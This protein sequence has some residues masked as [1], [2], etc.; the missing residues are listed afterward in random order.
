MGAR[1]LSP[2][3]ESVPP[4]RVV[5]IIA[6]GGQGNRLGADAPKQFLEIGGRTMLD[7][8]IA[9]FDAHPRVAALVVALPAA[10]M[11]DPPACLGACAK[12]LQLVAGGERRQDSVARA[13]EAIEPP[14]DVVVVHDAARP[15]VDAATIDRTIDAAI[16]SGAA[17]AA[18]PSRDTVKL[19]R[20]DAAGAWVTETIPRECVWLAQTPQ[21]F[22]RDVLAAAL[23]LGARGGHGTDEAALAEQAGHTVRLV[24]G[25]PRNIKI[26]T[27]ADLEL[28]RA[29]LAREA[30]PASHDV[31]LR[32]GMGYDSHRLVQ[33]RPL[34]LGGVAVPHTSGLAGYSDADALCHAITDAVLGAAALGDIGRHFPDTDPRWRDAD[35]LDLLRRAASL[36]RAAGFN[37]VNVDA[38]VIADQPKLAPFVDAMRARLADALGLEAGAVSVKGKTNEGMGETGRGEGIA[39]HAVALVARR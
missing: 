36:L 12:P 18:L 31:N 4:L 20:D 37:V 5:A 3:S 14:A 26:T 38:V 35:S 27:Q 32:I 22:R 25:N 33:G 6:A 17:I 1:S 34:V 19:A 10:V 16:E 7:R 13:F 28:A 30:Q 15:F 29:A 21:A 8:S 23:A 39:V 9:A 2:M 11:A 24:D